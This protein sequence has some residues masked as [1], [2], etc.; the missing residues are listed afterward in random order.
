MSIEEKKFLKSYNPNLYEKPSVTVDIA[1][2][3]IIDG[4][5]KVLLI[6]R[7]HPPYR[8]KWA[9]PGG[10]VDIPSKETLEETAARELFEETMLKDIFIEQLKT[11]G[12][13][14]RDP[15]MRIITVAYYALVPY[16]RVCFTK[17]GDDA[18]E[19]RWFPI[20]NLP[21]LAFDHKKILSDILTRLMGK[22]SY[23]TIA[24]NL[25]P[26]EFTWT[27][28]Q[29]VFEAILGRKFIVPDFRSSILSRY[30]IRTLNKK[31]K[32]DGRGRP[33]NLLNMTGEKKKIF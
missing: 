16:G 33:S 3:S 11:Y 4:E 9:I 24:F 14:N 32:M 7:K 2:C 25:V 20:R 18:A 1:I 15:R 30:D 23:T 5:L 22:V 26:P 19:T 28:L 17:A 6:K 13:P 29:G 8:D 31:K 21:E 10:F 27:E 12:D